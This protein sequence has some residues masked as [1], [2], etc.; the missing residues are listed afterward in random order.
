MTT[1][2]RRAIALHDELRELAQLHRGDPRWWVV[3]GGA[4][5]RWPRSPA[6]HVFSDGEPSGDTV[7]GIP[8]AAPT[9]PV[10]DAIARAHAARAALCELDGGLPE[11]PLAITLSREATGAR[12]VAS[13]LD[14]AAF[15]VGDRVVHVRI[16]DQPEGERDLI[17]ML[18]RALA[19]A[20]A[21]AAPPGVLADA[22]VAVTLGDEPLATARHAHRRGWRRNG[23]ASGPWLG[24]G[25]ADGLATTTTCHFAV[26]G[27]GHARIAARVGELAPAIAQRLA[28]IAPAER[29]RHEAPPPTIVAEADAEP[30]A[31]VWRV[32]DAPA[33]R[34]LAL[35]YRAGVALHARVGDRAARF[36][37]TIQIPVAPG[38]RDDAARMRRRIVPALVSV[39]FERGAP[40]PYDAFAARSRLAIAREV[41]GDGVLAQLL[42]AM[43]AAPAPLVWKRRTITPARPRWMTEIATM[44]GG[45]AC[46]S[47]IALDVAMPPACAVSAPATRVQPGDPIGGCVITVLDDGTRASITLCG[48]PSLAADELLDELVADRATT[49]PT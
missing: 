25:Y 36:S 31:V 14:V 30:L 9:D 42:V 22:F 41:R 27:Y 43:R 3:A 21:R 17:A 38:A 10:I 32:L 5:V 11:Q 6:V 12:A 18:D 20:S 4:A 23:H 47:R 46:V 29:L 15:A 35:A 33:P 40:E 16:A 13:A 26:D 37:P 34:A 24:L 2:M 44:L 48:T 49:S 7:I 28:A 19:G 8:T 45:R 1:W 39:R